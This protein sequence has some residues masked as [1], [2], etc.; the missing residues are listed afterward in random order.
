MTNFG[1]GLA[2]AFSS[3][4]R[5]ITLW[6]VLGFISLIGIILIGASHELKIANAIGPES[7]WF[8]FLRDLGLACLISVLIAITI[9]ISLA[10]R[11]ATGGLDAIMTAIIPEDVWGELRRHIV[12]QAVIREDY[13][14]T[15]SIDD[16]VLTNG[17]YAS[18]TT[19]L[20]SLR[21]TG[22]NPYTVE[23]ELDHHKTGHESGGRVLP[24]FESV[25]IQ[26]KVYKG[27]DLKKLLTPNGFGFTLK[28]GFQRAGEVLEFALVFREMVRLPDT[29]TWWMPVTTRC[30][31]FSVARMPVDMTIDVTACHPQPTLLKPRIPGSHWDF[32]GIMLPGQ[33]FE[34][35]T[36]KVVAKVV[37]NG[38]ESMAGGKG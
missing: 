31:A 16:E 9:E 28:L 2:R 32:D 23:H 36:S 33:A 25:T 27:D 1:L 3:V 26:D 15:M 6:V 35:R 24:R 34:I 4:K 29:F 37:A 17:S 14:L 20:Y 13:I 19:L 18:T 7:F 38:G 22:V 12:G 30:P 10:K 5:S 21:S 11:L 8:H